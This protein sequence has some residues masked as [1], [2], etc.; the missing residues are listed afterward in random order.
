MLDPND[1]GKYRPVNLRDDKKRA[2]KRKRDEALPLTKTGGTTLDYFRQAQSSYPLEAFGWNDH[3]KR[4]EKRSVGIGSASQ[5][6]TYW[7]EIMDSGQAT[8]EELYACAHVAAKKWRNERF[9]WVPNFSTFFG[10][11]KNLWANFL[12]EAKLA[13]AQLEVSDALG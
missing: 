13:L 5:A 7:L 8:A 1:E 2:P 11:E 9:L 4:E 12:P 10:P 3:T 6:E